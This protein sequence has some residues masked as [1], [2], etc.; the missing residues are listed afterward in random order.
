MH[1]TAWRSHGITL[2]GL[3]GAIFHGSCTIVG[4][5]PKNNAMFTMYRLSGCREVG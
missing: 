1:D 2:M 5:L 3:Y 4:S